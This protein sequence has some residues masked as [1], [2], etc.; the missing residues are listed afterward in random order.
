MG[1]G[2]DC[3]VII[4]EPRMNLILVNASYFL[5]FLVQLYAQNKFSDPQKTV[6]AILH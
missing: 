6:C 2:A 1:K 4:P 5:I 3:N